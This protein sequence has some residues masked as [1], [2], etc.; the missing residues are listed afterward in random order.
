MRV[1]GVWFADADGTDYVMVLEDLVA[2]GCTF[3]RPDDTDIE[4]RAHDIVVQCARLHAPSWEHPRFAPDGD[5]EWLV[6][7]GTG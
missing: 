1:P 7:R 4:A 6:A 3:P 2:S 5:L